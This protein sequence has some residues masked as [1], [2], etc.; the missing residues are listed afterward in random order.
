M[1][2]EERAAAL[3]KLDEL[4]ETKLLLIGPTTL[5]HP[6]PDSMSVAICT[7]QEPI[8]L[9][10]NA[11]MARRIIAHAITAACTEQR[12]KD[13]DIVRAMADST[14]QYQLAVRIAS[15]IEGQT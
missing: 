5:I 3:V 14:T 10:L 12:R 6:F 15:A 1:T 9:S 13:A 11:Q 4:D 8:V 2:P 7:S